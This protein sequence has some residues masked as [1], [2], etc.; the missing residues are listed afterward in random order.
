MGKTSGGNGV[1]IQNAEISELNGWYRK[2]ESTVCPA[3]WRHW[4]GD[5]QWYQKDDGCCIVWSDDRIQAE[6]KWFL[7][8]ATGNVIYA[9]FCGRES[10]P[11]GQRWHIWWPRAESK[12]V[13]RT[14]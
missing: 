10:L 11:E 5:R 9:K 7:R 6:R 3:K 2:R 14:Y 12:L 4:S 1:E 8:D 13:A